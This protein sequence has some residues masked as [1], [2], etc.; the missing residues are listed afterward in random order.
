[1]NTAAPGSWLITGFHTSPPSPSAAMNTIKGGAPG[2][3]LI[4]T[5]AMLTVT[6]RSRPGA[7]KL[8]NRVAERAP[9]LV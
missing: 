4:V 6:L 2:R 3:I 9:C 7:I 8:G 5:N 1:M